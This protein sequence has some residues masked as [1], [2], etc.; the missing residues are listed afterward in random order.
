MVNLGENGRLVI[1]ARF[2]RALGIEAG[3]QL[4]VTLDAGQLRITTRE[5]AVSRAQELVRQR[6][7]GDTS[8]VDELIEERRAEA[9]AD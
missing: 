4:V 2:R 5:H 3:D 7:G 8:L 9:R 1:P 6:V